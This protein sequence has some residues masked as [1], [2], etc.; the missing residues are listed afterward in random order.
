MF[1]ASIM[2][3]LI[4][5]CRNEVTHGRMILDTR[6]LFY[7]LFKSYRETMATLRKDVPE[8][9][10]WNPPPNDWIKCYVDAIVGEEFAID[11]LVVRD[12]RRELVY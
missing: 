5:M 7:K 12:F 8:V 10:E 6:S 9:V 11:A 2:I 1:F 3:D 4:W